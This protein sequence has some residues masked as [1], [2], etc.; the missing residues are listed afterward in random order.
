MNDRG[1][2]IVWTSLKSNDARVGVPAPLVLRKALQAPN[3]GTLISNVIRSSR[4]NGMNFI[5]ADACG[6]VDIDLSATR[7][8]V[9][10]C[11]GILTRANHYE[12][13]EM[14]SFEADLPVTAPDTLLRS[15]RMKEL[16]E[17]NE[18]AIDHEVLMQIYCDHAHAPGSICLHPWEGWTTAVTPLFDPS[19]G[20]MWASNGRPCE[21]GFAEYSLPTHAMAAT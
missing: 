12:S 18:G 3:L 14:L 2:A 1:L 9:T 10:Y 5:A 6:A 4:A 19:Q 16:L 17:R 8:Q 20:L 11:P 7:Y 13:P 15:G 21:A